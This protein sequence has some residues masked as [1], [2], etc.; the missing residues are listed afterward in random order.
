MVGYR[1]GEEGVDWKGAME[2]LC[3]RLSNSEWPN[4]LIYLS[5]GLMGSPAPGVYSMVPILV[6]PAASGCLRH[7]AAPGGWLL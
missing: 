4:L 2:G 6:V 7:S 3:T 5:K 1:G